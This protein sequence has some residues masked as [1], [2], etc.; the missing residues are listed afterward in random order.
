ME[1]LAG[2]LLTQL[3]RIPSGGEVVDYEGRRMTI[4]EMSGLRIAKVRV[5]KAPAVA[6]QEVPA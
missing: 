6:S 1:T 4:T 5:E 2:F 3:G